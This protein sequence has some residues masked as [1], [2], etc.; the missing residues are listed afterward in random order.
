MSGTL[1]VRKGITSLG[2]EMQI[3]LLLD[4][5]SY[6][7][8]CRFLS[9]TASNVGKDVQVEHLYCCQECTLVQS[10]KMVRHDPVK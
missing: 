7:L 5:I 4:T 10:W 1:N 2:E 9:L 8:Y 6:P 3:K